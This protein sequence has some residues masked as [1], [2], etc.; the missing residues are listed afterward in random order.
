MQSKRVLA[1]LIVLLA[2]ILGCSSKPETTTKGDTTKGSKPLGN[3][4][5]LGGEARIDPAPTMCDVQHATLTMVAVPAGD[6][7]TLTFTSTVDTPVT[8]DRPACFSPLKQAALLK[9]RRRGFTDNSVEGNTADAYIM[10]V[11]AQ[12]PQPGDTSAG[13]KYIHLI[14]DN[15]ASLRF[16]VL[17][18]TTTFTISN[19]P[20]PHIIRAFL[21]SDWSESVKQQS[22]FD[23]KAVAVNTTAPPPPLPTSPT[24][25]FCSPVHDRIYPGGTVPLD[26]FVSGATLGV[27]GYAVVLTLTGPVSLSQTLTVWQPYCISG[28]TPGDYTITLQLLQSGSPVPGTLAT[29]TDIF[30]VS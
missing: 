29:A 18:T 22:A 24:V 9:E 27:S 2:T 21:E 12:M 7:V 4:V 20:G 16:D 3:T 30:H 25:A 5:A 23:M 26:F 10:S 28:L 14:V 13:G 15:I 11:G 8:C 17:S 6:N 19:I 1:I